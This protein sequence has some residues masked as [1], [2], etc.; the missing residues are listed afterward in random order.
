MKCLKHILTEGKIL[1][2]NNNA[3]TVEKNK[4]SPYKMKTNTSSK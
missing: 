2:K 4:I 1:S 3:K